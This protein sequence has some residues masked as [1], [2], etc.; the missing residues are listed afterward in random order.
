[1]NLR[2]AETIFYVYMSI[3]IYINQLKIFFLFFLGEV[4]AGTAAKGEAFSTAPL[5]RARNIYFG[6]GWR[7]ILRLHGWILSSK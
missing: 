7:H 5:S 6:S 3:G 2:D 1:M 4:A